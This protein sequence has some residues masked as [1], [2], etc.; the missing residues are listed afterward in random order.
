MKAVCLAFVLALAACSGGPASEVETL[1]IVTE[2]FVISLRANGELRAG[3]STPITPPEG[4]RDPRTIAWLAP[5]FSSVRRGDVIA[6]FDA[7]EAEKEALQTGIELHKVDLQVLAKERELERLLSELGHDLELV[8]IEKLMAERFT[9]DD[10]L[11]YSRHEIIDATRDKALLEYRSEHLANKQGLYSDRQNAE[12][13]VLDAVRE[14]Q[15]SQNRQHRE[16]IDRSEVRAPHGGFLVYEKTWWGQQID[17]GSTVFPG[18]RIAS[19]PNLERMEAVLRVLE[20]EAVGLEDGQTVNL[21]IDA[22]PDRPLTGTVSAIS[23]TAAPIDRDSPV[24][25]FTVTVALD[26]SDPEWITP[27]AQVTAEI[28]I[29]R[30]ENAIAVPNQAVFRDADGDWVLLRDG[31]QLQRRT[32]S[33]GLR[34]ANRSQITA[35]LEAGDEIALYPP[36]EPES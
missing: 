12:I 18:N 14:T 21:R 3:E 11:A 23:A 20:T 19:I 16:Q 7:S 15:A 8:D 32:V 1:E 5:N 31:R 26:Q 17:V 10:S 29:D 36:G 25:Y 34:G 4:S 35:G 24:K 33:L 27:E 6:R 22:W 13:G 9:V 2:E 28:H 30:V